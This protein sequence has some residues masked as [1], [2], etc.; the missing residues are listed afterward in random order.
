VLLAN[1]GARVV[2]LVS[3]AVATLVIA[4]AGGPAAVGAYALLRVLPGLAGVVFASGLPGAVTY[5]LAGPQRDDRRLPL[6]IV[7]IALAGGTVGTLLWAAG[8]PLLRDLF[9]EDLS[10]LLVVLAGFTVLAQLL[11]ATA[12]SCSQ[13]SDDLRGANLVIV[14]EELLF[15]P[16][17]AAL[18]LAGVGGDMALVAGL[19]LAD[20][21][22][23]VPAWTRLYRR[24]FFRGAR[25]PSPGLARDVLSYGFR[26]QIGGVIMLM[27]LRLDFILIQLMAGPVVLGIYA[28]ASKFAEL[29]KVVSLALNYVLYPRFAR[30]GTGRAAASA[31]RLLPKSVLVTAGTAIPLI[32]TAGLLIPLAY[33][34]EFA[35]AVGPAQ[36]LLI[37]LAVDGAAGVLTGY[38]YGV[39]RPGLNSWAMAAGLAVTVTLDLLLIPAHGAAG[40][41]VASAVAYLTSTLTLLYF[42]WR[43]NRAP[44]PTA[45]WKASTVPRA[46]TR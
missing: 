12:K 3:L 11:V 18:L 7:G 32:L 27:N 29:V 33:G 19:L 41:A 31:R 5:F 44:V 6:T 45:P 30:E 2:A 16:A 35:A 42:F 28:I 24:G 23:F 46:E 9:F 21:A 20:V 36:V 14:N 43:L 22:A 26:A 15:L 40:A 25:R 34:S 37:G 13:G 17:Y 38:L 10:V 1:V 39:G 8:S 4:R